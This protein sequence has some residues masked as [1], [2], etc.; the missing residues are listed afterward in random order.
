M[1][2]VRI[3]NKGSIIPMVSFIEYIKRN[4]YE[5]H[6]NNH[7]LEHLVNRVNSLCNDENEID[8]NLSFISI[9]AGRI[10]D[11]FL[12]EDNTNS[13]EIWGFISSESFNKW[14]SFG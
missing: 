10:S 6:S 4:T 5:V 13:S 14:K 11:E 9:L 1:T 7:K 3:Y 2:D 12:K 8:K